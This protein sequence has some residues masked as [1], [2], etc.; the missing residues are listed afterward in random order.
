MIFGSLVEDVVSDVYADH[1]LVPR[2]D[3]ADDWRVVIPFQSEQATRGVGGG[4]GGR[5]GTANTTSN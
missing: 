2:R 5:P 4:G 1:D 3:R